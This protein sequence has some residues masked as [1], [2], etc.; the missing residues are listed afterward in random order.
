VHA[1]QTHPWRGI[2]PGAF[3]FYWAQ[4]G[5]ITL[6]VRDAH[7]L[8]LQ[9]LAELG[10]IG[11]VFIGGFLLWML[12]A[13]VVKTVRAGPTSGT[14]LA[15]ATA[16]CAAFAVSAAYEWVWQIAVLPL[17]V[18]VLA[19][20]IFAP[21][22]GTRRTTPR[23]RTGARVLMGLVAVVALV[24][25]GI[26]LASTTA[27]RRSQNEGQSQNLSAALSSAQ[28]AQR[29]ESSAGGPWLQEAL[30]Y[31]AQHSYGLAAGAAIKA[32]ENEPVNWRNWLVLSRIQAER[33]DAS[34]AATAY[35]KVRTLN[36]KLFANGQ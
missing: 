1:N 15:A 12:G 34:A 2:G 23:V 4:H 32:T 31:E 21:P 29:L 16:A 17:I 5:T 11:L 13:G 19:G 33:G 8:Y 26:P 24:A 30:V 3:Q 20:V 9:T 22:P 35:G 36:P 7:S 14:T 25:I 10:I 6:F 18:C 28:T 27:L